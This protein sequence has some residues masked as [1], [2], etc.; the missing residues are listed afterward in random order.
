MKK[1]A[2]GALL[3][4]YIG[5]YAGSLVSE[6]FGASLLIGL[7]PGIIAAALV[8]QPTHRLRLEAIRG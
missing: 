4:V 5:W 1:R 8:L 2:F 3:W 7:I 6:M